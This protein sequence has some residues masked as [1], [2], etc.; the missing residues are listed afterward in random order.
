MYCR[1]CGKQIDYDAHL[2]KDCQQEVLNA[3]LIEKPKTEEVQPVVQVE[4]VQPQYTQTVKQ[5]RVGSKTKGLAKALTSAVVG[6]FAIVMALIAYTILMMLAESIGTSVRYDTEYYEAIAF[7]LILLSIGFAIPA[8]S[9]GIQS[10]SCFFKQN[11]EGKVRPVPTLAFGIVGV[12]TSSLGL[13][14]ATMAFLLV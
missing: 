10:M 2:C 11:R 14:Y 3:S 6:V 5:V 12:A 13:L 1:K 7:T 8:L 4:K 9:L